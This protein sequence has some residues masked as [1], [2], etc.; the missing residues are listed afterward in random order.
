MPPL[1][2]FLRSVTSFG[3]DDSI[4]DCCLFVGCL[5]VH[6]TR[7]GVL[8]GKL[9]RPNMMQESGARLQPPLDLPVSFFSPN[10]SQLVNLSF[11]LSAHYL[12]L[13]EEY[14]AS[15]QGQNML[16]HMQMWG[17]IAMMKPRDNM[18]EV[19]G[20][21]QSHSGEVIRFEKVST[22]SSSPQVRIA[23]SDWIDTLLPNLGYGRS[24]LIELPLI[25]IPSIPEAYK[26]AAEALDKARNAF[27]H[28]DYRSAMKYGREVLERLAESVSDKKISTLCKEQLEPVIGETKSHTVDGSLNILRD[29]TNAASHAS[30][31]LADRA[32]ASYVIETLALNLRYISSVLG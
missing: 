30:D 15:Q 32:T 12:Q 28:E 22:E 7:D 14:R 17:V 29:I 3:A 21:L 23:R 1:C 16:L 2:R 18:P 6:K 13:L 27:N 5:P 9:H 25:H 19:P 11:A 10:T 8:H 26:M 20:F 31:F 4:S 24:V